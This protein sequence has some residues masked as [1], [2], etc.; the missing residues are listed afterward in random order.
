MFTAP[1]SP[2][3]KVLALIVT[4]P[5]KERLAVSIVIPPEDP[6]AFGYTWLKIELPNSSPPRVESSLLRETDSAARISM[7]PAS[8]SP[9]VVALISDLSAKE[10]LAV[11]IVI[12]PEDPTAPDSTWLKIPPRE[13]MLDSPDRETESVAWTVTDPAFPLPAVEVIT[14]LPPLKERDW[15]SIVTPPEDPT[16]PDSTWLKIPLKK[17]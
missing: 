11:S 14:L 13:P 9:T 4:L 6:T 2:N 8:P 10:R 3:P 16:A 5:V 7:T 1:E 17:P 15:A 12:L